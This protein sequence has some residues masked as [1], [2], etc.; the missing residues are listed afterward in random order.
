MDRRVEHD[1]GDP[2][3]PLFFGVLGLVM[4]LNYDANSVTLLWNYARGYSMRDNFHRYHLRPFYAKPHQLG[5]G[6]HL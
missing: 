6:L 5:V 4:S 2:C 3:A 1:E